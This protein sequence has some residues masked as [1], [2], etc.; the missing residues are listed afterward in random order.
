[1]KKLVL[2][3]IAF[4]TLHVSAQEQKRELKK[5]HR[6]ENANYSPEESAQLQTK[7]LTLKLD[8]NEKQQKEVSILFLEEATLRQSRKEAFSEVKAKAENNSL[9]KEDRLKMKNDR[10]DHQ[11]ALKK[12]MK[13]ILSTEQYDKWGTMSSKQHQNKKQFKARNKAKQ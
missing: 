8:L 1:M 2:I 6:S 7:R 12:K 9:S 4:A 10:L 13:S 5:Q 3:I 11:I